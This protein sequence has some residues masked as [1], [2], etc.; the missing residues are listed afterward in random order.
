[1]HEILLRI[2]KIIRLL[3]VWPNIKKLNFTRINGYDDFEKIFIRID[4]TVSLRLKLYEQNQIRIFL[5]AWRL[6]EQ[7]LKGQNS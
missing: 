7:L 3:F 2:I 5:H 6:W 1:M 4:L